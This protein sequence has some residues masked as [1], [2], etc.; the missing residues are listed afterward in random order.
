MKQ[1]E[2]SHLLS[3][4][5]PDAAGVLQLLTP[6]EQVRELLR[7]AE[8]PEAAQLS[9]LSEE[10]LERRYPDKIKKLSPRRK[11][12]RVIDALMLGAS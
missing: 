6:P 10:T 7:I 2:I 4:L 9:S 3:E 5:S 1:V 12:M 8:M 11:G